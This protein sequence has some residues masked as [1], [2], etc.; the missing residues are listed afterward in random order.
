MLTAEPDAG[1]LEKLRN[2]GRIG[3]QKA[4]STFK[5]VIKVC[6]Q[7]VMGNDSYGICLDSQRKGYLCLV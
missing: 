3:S 5:N 4:M 7:G 1:N 2:R 6:I